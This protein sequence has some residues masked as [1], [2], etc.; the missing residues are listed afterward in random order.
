MKRALL[1]AMIWTL[2]GCANGWIGD[3][4]AEADQWGNDGS[5]S[6]D[7]D[8]APYDEV[9]ELLDD[10]DPTPGYDPCLDDD[11]CPDDETDPEED[12]AGGAST[13]GGEGGED[14]VGGAG[15]E[16]DP[17]PTTTGKYQAGDLLL[18]LKYAPLRKEPKTGSGVKSVH[19]N[20]G[21]HGGH[22]KGTVPP[23]QQVRM[24][25]QPRTNGYYKVEYKGYNGWIYGK[26]LALVDEGIHPVKFARRAA[27][28]DAFFM[29][30]IKRSKW[31]KD[32]PSSSANCAPTSL[33]MAAKI[34]DVATRGRTIERGIHEA[35][36]SYNASTNESIGTN[37]AQIRQG[38]KTL[39]FTVHELATNLPSASD[40]MNRLD[41][42]LGWNRV[43]VLE[44]QAYGSQGAAYRSRMTAAFHDGG[45]TNRTYYY[46][47]RHSILVVARLDNGK[48]VVGDPIS[49][50]G[51]V[52]MSR[53]QLKS[54]I[55]YWGGTGN[56]LHL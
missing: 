28:R 31:N 29:H 9:G 21:V 11:I 56:A 47:G 53:T 13:E 22:P 7:L 12:G 10:T 19:T 17:P 34:F 14:G 32:G 15:T 46:Q 50:V 48:Y 39:G 40:E 2:A 8:P 26:K 24:L 30:Q 25:N 18:V 23:G 38:A 16:T 49:E 4:G 55:K 3:S 35:R 1:A 52:T 33:A 27:V 37:R 36:D 43:V 45:V 5:E 42:Q 54:F 51:M 20:G 44:G 6:V 41:K